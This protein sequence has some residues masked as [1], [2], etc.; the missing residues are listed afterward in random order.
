MKISQIQ[1]LFLYPVPIITLNS[2]WTIVVKLTSPMSNSNTP[3]GLYAFFETWV[4]NLW[5]CKR[6]KGHFTLQPVKRIRDSSNLIG[7]EPKF[8]C[9]AFTLEAN[10]QRT[11]ASKTS[12]WQ[13]FLGVLVPKVFRWRKT[14]L[15][16]LWNPNS[17]WADKLFFLNL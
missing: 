12:R 7:G 1:M 13:H 14:C 6:H 16:Y 11:R 8:V 15:Q 10:G 17:P 2:C 5:T 9:L 3:A 4:N